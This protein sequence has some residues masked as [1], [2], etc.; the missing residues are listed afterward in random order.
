MAKDDKKRVENL[1]KLSKAREEEKK[2]DKELADAK[3]VNLEFVHKKLE[4]QRLSDS[5]YTKRHIKELERIADLNEKIY[6]GDVAAAKEL[7][8]LG[9]EL[10][11][12]KQS[13]FDIEAEQNEERKLWTEEES[14]KALQDH[15]ISVESTLE[16]RQLEIELHELNAAHE[17]RWRTFNDLQQKATDLINDPAGFMK[18]MAREK[19]LALFSKRARLASKIDA[20]DAEEQK[21]KS[22]KEEDE[23]LK[24]W[25]KDIEDINRAVAGITG[26]LT[27]E[28]QIQLEQDT[29]Q[30]KEDNF[31]S[32]DIVEALED[33]NMI[34]ADTLKQDAQQHKDNSETS[35]FESL[36]DGTTAVPQSREMTIAGPA[37]TKDSGFGMPDPK[38]GLKG[39][40]GN[41]MGKFGKAGK[42]LMNFGAKFLMP[43]ITT[44]V[45]WAILAGL[46]VGGLV[47]AYWDDIVAFVG[48]MFTGIKSMFSKVVSKISGMF[49]A[50]GNA[51]KEVISFFN[52][53]N[54]AKTIAKALL[55]ADMYGAVSSFFGGDNAEEIESKEKKS[56]LKKE[57]AIGDEMEA[58]LSSAKSDQLDL[59]K[60]IN[61]KNVIAAEKDGEVITIKVGQKFEGSTLRSANHAHWKLKQAGYKVLSPEETNAVMDRNEEDIKQKEFALDT[62]VKREEKLIDDIS[63]IDESVATG[64]AK[65]DK[66]GN[67]VADLVRSGVV[68]HSYLGNST[69][70]DWGSLRELD[71][72]TLEKVLAFDDWN[73]KTKRGILGIM[74]ENPNE[75]SIKK[76]DDM[77]QQAVATGMKNKI[78]SSATT[79]PSTSNNTVVAPTNINNTTVK[80]SS[81]SDDD[82]TNQAMQKGS[83]YASEF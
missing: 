15:A 18:K 43:L 55:P 72:D 11:N 61:S 7:Q 13:H 1:A 26:T 52:P 14:Q 12:L 80:Q 66:P 69:V 54:L 17:E 68:D 51:I 27:V 62:Q 75:I 24:G 63:T 79:A 38:K 83:A 31:I 56:T 49:S 59:G 36:G 64:K 33:G 81:S 58:E 21:V 40:L 70:K 71:Y 29:D 50:V 41:I 78:G 57:Q 37:E 30:A 5:A 16:R 45:G 8:Q 2:Q 34:A 25:K 74:D 6:N 77:V 65:D 60:S 42:F 23:K 4:E 3:K 48:K 10:S 39:I 32:G 73:D 46:A 35:A 76:K 19:L 82:V 47:F 9:V 67:V 22:R 44:P 53:I 28:Q 20:I